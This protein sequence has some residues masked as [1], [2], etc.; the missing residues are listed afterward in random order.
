M[1][2]MHPDRA[3]NLGCAIVPYE[4]GFPIKGRAIFDGTRV[5][6]PNPLEADRSKGPIIEALDPPRRKGAQRP[7]NKGL[8]RRNLDAERLEKARQL[9]PNY[10]DLRDIE[11]WRKIGQNSPRSPHAEHAFVYRQ[12]RFDQRPRGLAFK[13]WKKRVYQEMEQLGL[14]DAYTGP[15][16][17]RMPE[18]SSKEEA[19]EEMTQETMETANDEQRQRD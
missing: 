15:L 9:A 3:K 10:P 19:T 14:E 1:A 8:A 7:T 17:N 2:S 13:E 16:V 18:G 11:A 12:L 4:R 5:P 6:R